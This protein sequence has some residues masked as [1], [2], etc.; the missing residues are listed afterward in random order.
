M[1]VLLAHIMAARQAAKGGH[2]DAGRFLHR[3]DGK[4]FSAI[5][6]HDIIEI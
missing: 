4:V 1:M 5:L 3:P 2:P 6:N